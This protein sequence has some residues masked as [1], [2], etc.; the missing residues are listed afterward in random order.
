MARSAERNHFETWKVPLW[1]SSSAES[2]LSIGERTSYH[3]W[4]TCIFTKVVNGNRIYIAV[5]VDDMLL[6]AKL[7]MDIS[8]V[9]EIESAIRA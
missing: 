2:L 5:S 6:F 9:K 7:L 8:S 3:P 1:Y 4:F